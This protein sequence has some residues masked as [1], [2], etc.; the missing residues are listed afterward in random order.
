[1][2]LLGRY[3]FCKN[4]EIELNIFIFWHGIHILLF[5]SAESLNDCI[6]SKGPPSYT[7]LMKETKGLNKWRCML[8]SW[9]WRL[10]LVKMSVLLNSFLSSKTVV[11]LSEDVYP[12]VSQLLIEVESYVFLRDW[13]CV[14]SGICTY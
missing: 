11:C 3:F 4:V 7:V 5:I 12:L 10:N 14:F 8:C 9:I 2:F 1:M 13:D 6:I